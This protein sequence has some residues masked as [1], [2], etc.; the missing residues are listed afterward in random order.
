MKLA[1]FDV[2]LDQPFFL[3]A[4]PCVIESRDMAFDTAATLKEITSALGIPFIYKS[5]FDKANRS[6]GKSYRG[7]GME[8]GLQILADVKHVVILGGGD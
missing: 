7:P 4:G 8:Q 2:G 5:S 3:I 1:G 6:S